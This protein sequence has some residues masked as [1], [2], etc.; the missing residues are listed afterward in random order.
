[1][2]IP[3]GPMTCAHAT[4]QAMV[5]AVQDSIWMLS[6]FKEAYEGTLPL[7]NLLQLAQDMQK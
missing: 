7:V 2:T 4:L 1:M 6:V 5:R 3:I